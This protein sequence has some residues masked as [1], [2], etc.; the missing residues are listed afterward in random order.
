[1]RDSPLRVILRGV[2][3]ET[4]GP[5]P[6]LPIERVAAALEV[7]LCSGFPTQLAVITV[8]STFGMK[9]RL[10]GGQLAPAFVFALTLSDT[11]LL[12]AL[13]FLFLRSHRESPRLALFAQRR[14]GIE[15]ALGI[16]IIPLSFM[17]VILVL[18]IIQM[19]DPALHNVPQNPFADLARTRGAAIMFGFVVMVAGGVREE[20][21]RGFILHRFEQYLGGGPL[22]LALFSVVFGLGHI[23][24]GYDVAVATAAL[25]AFWGAL[26][27]ARRSVVAP[28]VA[29]AGFNLAQVVKFFFLG[30]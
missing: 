17:L 26:Y 23:E 11:V 3:D 30:G 13:V 19:I 7:I 16:A 14:T 24:Q 8:L 28:M 21:Q 18:A 2:P 1:M 4:T 9:V 20:I 12:V 15:I 6:I 29:H 27:L 10:G 5:R 22:G 25:G